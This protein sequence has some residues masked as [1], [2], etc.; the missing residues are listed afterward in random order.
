MSALLPEDGDRS[1][2]WVSWTGEGMSFGRVLVDV[3]AGVWDD[4]WERDRGGVIDRVREAS[5]VYVDVDVDSAGTDGPG[6]SFGRLVGRTILMGERK[7]LVMLVDAGSGWMRGCQ[8][9]TSEVLYIEA[10]PQ[11]LDIHLVTR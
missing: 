11:I 5:G 2:M 1:R 7:L 3:G 6:E 9:R 8:D 4:D 10:V